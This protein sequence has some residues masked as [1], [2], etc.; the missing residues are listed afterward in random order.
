MVLL[1]SHA[2]KKSLRPNRRKLPFLGEIRWFGILRPAPAFHF[3]LMQAVGFLYLAYRFASR[4]YSIY[5]HLAD[6]Y[7]NYPRTFS[8]ELW[9]TPLLHF[10]SFHFIYDF[11]PIPSADLIAFMQYGVVAACLAGLIGLFPKISAII[12]FILAIHIT[13][14]MHASNA[15]IDGGALA[16]CLVLILALSPKSNFYSL[17][18]FEPFK[19]KIDHH[20][21]VFLL[22][23]FVGAFYTMGGLNKVFDVGPHWGSVVGLD[24][25]ALHGLE[26]SLFVSS[27][28]VEPWVSYIMLSKPLAIF[29]GWT[30][31]I[32][33]IGFISILFLP[34]F[35]AFFVL[36]MIALHIFVFQMAGINFVGS[37]CVLLLCMDWNKLIERYERAKPSKNPAS[38]DIIAGLETKQAG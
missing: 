14:F 22:F 28:F 6:T 36:S 5:G 13:S 8:F 12:A 20:W 25:L 31:F 15:E 16:L 10:V 3:Y 33:E 1:I 29:A 4:D 24:R 9:G 35:R 32:G 30:S 17:K 26:N 23:L 27:R 19:R 11:I 37:S 18:K 21:P 7:F 34:R 38:S 2:L